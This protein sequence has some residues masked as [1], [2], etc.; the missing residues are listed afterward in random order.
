MGYL[1]GAKE[2]N[3]LTAQTTE[4]WLLT[5]RERVEEVEEDTSEALAKRRELVKLLVEQIKVD[6]TEDGHTQVHITY[7]FAS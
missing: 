7:R 5:L 1:K 3:K 2:E 6:R 4:A